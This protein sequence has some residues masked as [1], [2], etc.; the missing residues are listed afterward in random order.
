MY[1]S[2]LWA[3][4]LATEAHPIARIADINPVLHLACQSVALRIL[5]QILL[6]VVRSVQD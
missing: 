6:V 1:D 2:Q 3:V 4:R 5:L